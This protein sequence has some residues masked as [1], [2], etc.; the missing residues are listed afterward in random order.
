MRRCLERPA[1]S[2]AGL[3]DRLEAA[4]LDLHQHGVGGQFVEVRA[5]REHVEDALKEGTYHLLS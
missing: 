5:R 2:G 3:H 4:V 1:V